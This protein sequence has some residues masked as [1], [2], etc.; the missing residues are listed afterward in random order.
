MSKPKTFARELARQLRDQGRWLRWRLNRPPAP[1]TDGLRLHLGC[2]TID[3][4]G[5]VNIDGR[6]ARHVHHVQGLDRLGNFA[7]GSAEMVYACHCLEHIA[8]DDLPRVLAEWARVL[9]PG[10]VLRVSVPDF[11]L[12]VDTYLDTGRNVHSVQMPLMG[13][14]NY[15]LN[16]HYV[17]FT[18]RY[19]TEL[20]L[21]AGL[22]SPRRWQHG[23]DAWAQLP[24][25]SGRSMVFEGKNYPV[26]LN[27]QATK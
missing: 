25:W 9:K 23:E 16:F 18:E 22:H 3:H 4:P 12:L 11:D 19:L 15:P 5:F 2:G 8:R 24:D 20:M 10:G 26:S 27:L 7:S 14:Q 6:P 17:A 21:Q 13:E 1:R